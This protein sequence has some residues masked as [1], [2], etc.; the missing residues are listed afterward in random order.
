MQRGSLEFND[1]AANLLQSLPNVNVVDISRIQHRGQWRRFAEKR[2]E[3]T[4]KGNGNPNELRLWHDTGTTDPG[5]ILRSESG[6]DERMSSKGFYG[7]G[8]YFAEPVT[9]L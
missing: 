1:V 9:F 4:V 3:L 6:L 2:R 8:I 7:R 5:V